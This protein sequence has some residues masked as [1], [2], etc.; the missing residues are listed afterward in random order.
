M[1]DDIPASFPF[2][3]TGVS[4]QRTAPKHVLD[5]SVGYSIGAWEADAFAHYESAFYGLVSTGGFNYAQSRVSDYLAIDGRVGYRLT[6]DVTLAVS[7]QNLGLRTQRQT[8]IGTVDRR[9]LATV[10]VRF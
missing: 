1:H 6:K 2:T 8:T 5:A 7:G 9:V 4:Y 3:Q 10:S